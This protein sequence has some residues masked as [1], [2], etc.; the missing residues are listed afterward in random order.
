MADPLG[1]NFKEFIA[2][3]NFRF[4]KHFAVH[5]QA[6]YA[7]IGEDDANNNGSNI[8]LSDTIGTKN[9][10]SVKMGQGLKGT[11]NYV[12]GHISYLMNP[13]TNMNVVLGITYR[14]FKEASSTGTG[15]IKDPT[16]M[17]FY[18]GFRTSIT[19]SYFDF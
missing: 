2:Q 10:S 5:L 14:G 1:A 13:K 18:I 4:A 3:V 16:T 8:F 6:N 9:I 7:L 11:L 19:N 12:D 17:L 15:D